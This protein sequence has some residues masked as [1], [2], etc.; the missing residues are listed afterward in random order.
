MFLN[1]YLLFILHVFQFLFIKMDEICFTL[2]TRHFENPARA[3]WYIWG[4][5]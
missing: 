2:C 5:T 3:T 1:I 4:H